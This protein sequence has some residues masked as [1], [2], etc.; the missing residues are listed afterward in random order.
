MR[1]QKKGRGFLLV[2]EDDTGPALAKV[3][4]FDMYSNSDAVILAR[5][6]KIV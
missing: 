3:C 1:A 6:A 2:F 5:A 4:E